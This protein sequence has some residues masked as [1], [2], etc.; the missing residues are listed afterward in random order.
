MDMLEGSQIGHHRHWM[1]VVLFKPALDPEQIH[2]SGLMSDEREHA[3]VRQDG[4]I[5]EPEPPT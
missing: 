3:V 4:L 2:W 1:L 5:D